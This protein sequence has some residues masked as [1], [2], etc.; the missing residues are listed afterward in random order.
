MRCR[1]GAACAR[2]EQYEGEDDKIEQDARQ[3]AAGREEQR[4]SRPCRRVAE[5][6]VKMLSQ[7]NQDCYNV[8]ALAGNTR[9][10][11]QGAVGHTSQQTGGGITAMELG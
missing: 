11:P 5:R 2:E 10:N 1:K 8:L 4:L 7:H 9:K 6:V 3:E